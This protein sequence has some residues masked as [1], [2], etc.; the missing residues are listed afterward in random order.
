MPTD[1][2]DALNESGLA[3]IGAPGLAGALFNRALALERLGPR[4]L[5]ADAWERY[6]AADGSSPWAD[7]ARTRLAAIR[8]RPVDP[9]LQTTR[10]AIRLNQ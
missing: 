1:A 2:V 6:L 3:I 8:A 7:E 4:T 5:A 9:H 10:R